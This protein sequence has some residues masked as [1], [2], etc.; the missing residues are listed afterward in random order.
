MN[1]I[2]D[3]GLGPNSNISVHIHSS[4]KCK[5]TALSTTGNQRPG[6]KTEQN[7]RCREG[8]RKK[9]TE[10]KERSLGSETGERQT[11]RE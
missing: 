8:G 9:V 6:N 10:K 4:Y 3:Y 5:R 11:V 7:E 1:Q 2:M